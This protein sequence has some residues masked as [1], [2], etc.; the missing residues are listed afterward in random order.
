MTI[1]FSYQTQH[2]PAPYAYAAFLQLKEHSDRLDARLSV[3][4]LDRDALTEDEIIAEGFS[5]NDDMEWEGTIGRNWK[6]IFTMIQQ[7]HFIQEPAEQDYLHVSIDGVEKGF[8][9][10]TKS[11]VYLFQELLQAV[12]E[13]ADLAPPL[14]IIWFDGSEQRLHWTFADRIFQ[15]NDTVQKDW[16]KGQSILAAIYEVE[17]DTLKSSNKPM[18]NGL[19]FDS[20]NWFLIPSK[21]VLSAV[22]EV[23]NLSN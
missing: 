16:K 9:K 1:E 15:L 17:Y 18:N 6:V 14:E 23:I 11:A 19:S 22:N 20:Q 7:Y 10:E 8:P 3:S 21:A 2:L 5:P 13:K 12:Y 4:Y